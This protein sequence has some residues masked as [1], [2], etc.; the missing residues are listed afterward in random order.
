MH[1]KKSSN[2]KQR[3]IKKRKGHTFFRK[4]KKSENIYKIDTKIN[5]DFSENK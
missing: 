2:K 4:R 1:N 5:E 3:T